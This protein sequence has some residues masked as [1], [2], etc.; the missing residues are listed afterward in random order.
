MHCW[1]GDLL[2]TGGALA[3]ALVLAGR[4]WP[5]NSSSR[6]LVAVIT[7]V[8]GVLFTMASEIWN[9]Q[10]TGAWGYAKAMPVIFG[11]GLSPLMQWI[12]V[13]GLALTTVIRTRR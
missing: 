6:L 11:V 3:V 9:V 8:A 13:P 10:Y 12:V 5:T 1:L 4:S 2:I 7:I